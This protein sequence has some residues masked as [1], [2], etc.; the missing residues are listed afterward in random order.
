MYYLEHVV[1]TTPRQMKFQ[2][3][4]EL[5]PKVA[6]DRDFLQR[7]MDEWQPNI[8]Q[9]YL[10][11]LF[12]GHNQ[13]DS[14]VLV[15][16]DEIIRVLNEELKRIIKSKE[17]DDDK[18]EV[19]NFIARMERHKDNG[20]DWM[21]INGQHR[22]DSLERWMD[23]TVPNPSDFSENIALMHEDG[24][25]L[26]SGEIDG[27]LF[28]KM[29]DEIKSAFLDTTH[30][31]TFVLKFK[32]MDDL[33]QIVKLHNEGKA[34]NCNEWRSISP[35][36]I[37]QE[38]TKMNDYPD[39][40]SIF[41]SV[42]NKDDR[43]HISKKGVVCFLT[44]QYYAWNKR[45]ES[46]WTD[47]P[48]WKDEIYDEMAKISSDLWT[49]KSVDNFLSFS[50][51]VA[52]EYVTLKNTVWKKT[53]GKGNNKTYA[54]N[55]V[56]TF[57][58]YF[59][60]RMILDTQRH[61]LLNDVYKV[62]NHG[63]FAAQWFRAENKRQ[64]IRENLI[65]EGQ[66]IW[67]A[68]KSKNDPLNLFDGAEGKLDNKTMSHIKDKYMKSGISHLLDLKSS[69]SGSQLERVM[70]RMVEGFLEKY[71]FMMSKGYVSRQGSK[72]T[73]AVKREVFSL[74]LEEQGDTLKD[75]SDLLDGSKTHVGHQIASQYGGD[76][77]VDNLKLE[78]ASYNLSNKE[79][80]PA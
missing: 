31:V 15:S 62:K 58:N 23:G 4:L 69:Y 14:F 26:T 17:L 61:P 50:K 79:N 9:N 38:F 51:K 32:D 76:Y 6:I 54:K 43:Y 2:Q 36:Y 72:P 5:K 1:K 41:S 28:P 47:I 60:F 7:V 75:I 12:R 49:T 57:R 56:A 59:H 11:G 48:G 66:D 8:V 53:K 24:R 73:S 77:S 80:R 16:I 63:E 33:A 35:S 67:D 68:Y 27:K 30:P 20:K 65:A 18:S 70:V 37:M 3:W 42:T 45:A 52:R 13:I 22:D 40:V 74:G 55:T 44:H 64:S 29:S 39:F 34:W 78:D 21:L 25:P 71:D 10:N 46:T 19:Q